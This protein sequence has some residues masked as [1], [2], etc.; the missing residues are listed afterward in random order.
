MYIS[1][2]VLSNSKSAPHLTPLEDIHFRERLTIAHPEKRW[3]FVSNCVR[4]I[5]IEFH[6]FGSCSEV[7]AIAS[8]G[9][10]IEHPLGVQMSAARLGNEL[11]LC[12]GCPL[13]RLFWTGYPQTVKS[14]IICTHPYPYPTERCRKAQNFLDDPKKFA[15][16][17]VYPQKSAFIQLK[18]SLP[19]FLKTF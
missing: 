19:K 1:M 5:S 4:F 14:S 7:P 13:A 12:R 16:M 18:T 15:K 9:V 17:S 6:C 2:W 10:L 8:Y 3:K 11:S